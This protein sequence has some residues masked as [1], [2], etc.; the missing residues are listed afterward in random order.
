MRSL[1]VFAGACFVPLQAEVLSVSLSDNLSPSLDG[2]AG[3]VGTFWNAW[4]SA[5]GPLL[6]SDGGSS[7][8]RYVV[9]A[10]GP[11]ADWWCDLELLTGGVHVAG[12]ETSQLVISGL[13]LNGVYD[14][15]VASAW[16]ENPVET[17]FTLTNGSGSPSVQ[18]VGNALTGNGGSWERGANFVFFQDVVP[19]G[20]G[21]IRLSFTGP[22]Y[23]I[24]NGFQLV[25]PIERPVSS[26]EAWAA[27][28]AQ[29]LVLGGNDGE[30]DDPDKDGIGNLLE[31]GL[32]GMPSVYAREILPDFSKD[33]S[34]WIFVYD[35]NDAAK[36]PATIQ[37]VEYTFDFE[38]WTTVVIPVVSSAQV[39]IIDNGPT[40]HVRVNLPSSQSRIFA[41][42][43]VTR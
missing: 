7:S 2:P 8:V 35:R 13:E 31:F 19:D 24:V 14:L 41:R 28:P 38:T 30:L 17:T 40:N 23:G 32:D 27:N 43:K 10:D 3:S 26:F 15:Y 12:G 36:P 20:A 6:K 18:S 1:L 34:G 25:G 42:L 9:E 33:G 5:G 21:E 22:V 37:E 4:D 29:G 16:G 11:H 39:R